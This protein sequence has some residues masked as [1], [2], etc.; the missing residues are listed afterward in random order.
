MMSTPTKIQNQPV[1]MDVQD[2][3]ANSLVYDF[4][5]RNSFNEIASEFQKISHEDLEIHHGGLKLEHLVD[6]LFVK[7]IVYDFLRRTAHAKIAFE[8]KLHFGPFKNLDGLTLEKLF[9]MYKEK[10]KVHSTNHPVVEES[11]PSNQ[12]E[13]IPMPSTNLTLIKANKRVNS[14]VYEYL[15]RNKHLDIAIDFKQFYQSGLF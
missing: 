8:F 10:F 5:V 6:D 13:N 2:P 15:V 14:L 7:S 4:L 11:K 12:S 3:L 1:P 9:D